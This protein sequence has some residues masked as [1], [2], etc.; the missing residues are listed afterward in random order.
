MYDLAKFDEQVELGY[1]RRVESGPLVLYNYTDACTYEKAWGTIYTRHAR[2]II[3]EKATGKLV[4]QPLSKFFNIGETEET[5]LGNLPDEPYEVFDKLDGSL[6]IIYYYD[7]KWNVA[8]R[9]SF[10]S[11]QAVKGFEILNS[12]KTEYLNPEITYLAEII[13]PDNKIVVNYGDEE[14]LVLLTAYKQGAEISYGHLCAISNSTNIPKT[15]RYDLTIEQMIEMQAT[16][17][18]DQEGFVVRFVNGLRIKIKGA[19]YLRIHKMIANMS[20]LSFWESMENGIV[21]KMYLAEL[22]EE[23]RAD[24]EPIVVELEEQYLVVLNEI[25]ADLLM[26]PTTDVST[27]EGKKVVGMYVQGLNDLMHSTA[28][29]PVLLGNVRALDKYIMKYIRPKGNVL[30]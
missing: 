17:P 21:N 27:K 6:G 1:V 20:P 8:T 7:G 10:A 2:G 4:A 26:L 5:R 23:F 19:E 16:M 18:K 9:G 30:A 11:E 25:H 28:M 22:P 29:F 15:N 13:Y 14:K 3:F 12:Y 24:F